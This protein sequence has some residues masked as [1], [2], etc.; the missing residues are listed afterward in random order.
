MSA[1]RHY[2][3]GF[4]LLEVM[5]ASFVLSV[6][7]LGVA[8]LQGVS[9]KMTQGSYL[10]LQAVNLSYEIIDA[11]RANRTA[12]S[13]AGYN[14]SVTATCNSALTYSV[15][16]TVAKADLTIWGNRLACLLPN[17]SGTIAQTGN[18]FTVRVTW[19]DTRFDGQTD[20]AD[21]YHSFNFT[22][23]L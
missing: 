18:L 11:M 20:S 9:L 19:N 1:H 4:T 5:I 16:S 10:R 8:G 15:T 6:G 22:T 2:Q 3:Q 23:E 17:G 14:G 13:A 12:A 21:T 7:L